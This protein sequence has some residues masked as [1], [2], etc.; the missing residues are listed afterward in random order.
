M[1]HLNMEKNAFYNFKKYAAIG[2]IAISLIGLS[3]CATSTRVGAA[4]SVA[5]SFILPVQSTGYDWTQV[6][7]PPPTPNGALDRAEMD[8][9][10]QL[11]SLEGSARWSQAIQDNSFDIYKIYGPIIGDGFTAANRPEVLAVM[12]YAGRRLSMASSESKRQFA[13]PRPFVASSDLRICLTTPPTEFSYPSG[14][15]GWGWLSALIMARI[16]PTHASAILA[17]GR[18]YGQSRVVCAVHYETD[19]VAGRYLADAVLAQL[20]FDPEYQRL[21]AAARGN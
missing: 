19:T 6:L 2:A 12:A 1:F 10:R 17:R 7:P 9:V 4:T 5:K 21:L 20:E 18:E 16:E 3:A 11:Q 13:R 8:N 15:S 14:H